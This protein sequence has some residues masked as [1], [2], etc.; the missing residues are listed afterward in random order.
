MALVAA[1]VVVAAVLALVA[2]LL[3]V[4]LLQ[5]ALRVARL[6]PQLLHLLVLVRL[7]VAAVRQVPLPAEQEVAAVVLVEGL[8]AS[9]SLRSR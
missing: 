7:K 6:L 5:A 4:L 3:P 2:R 8:V 1:V 9:E